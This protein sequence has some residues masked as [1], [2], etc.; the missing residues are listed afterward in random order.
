MMMPLPNPSAPLSEVRAAAG[1]AALRGLS[2]LVWSTE[3]LDC[4]GSLAAL[5]EDGSEFPLPPDLLDRLAGSMTPLPHNGH[6]G[7]AA[8][9]GMATVL[10]L[11]SGAR[12]G[13][14]RSYRLERRSARPGLAVRSCSTA[15]GP[16]GTPASG[17]RQ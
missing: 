17:D 10:A 3:A 13:L 14:T 16:T 6:P 8:L 1:L 7:F 9:V 11:A 12:A 5:P 2:G 4:A 15:A